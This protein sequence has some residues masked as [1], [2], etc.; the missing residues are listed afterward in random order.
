MSSSVPLPPLP[1][2]QRVGGSTFASSPCYSNLTE[3]MG[4]GLGWAFGV[5][6]G[7]LIFFPTMW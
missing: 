1:W 2:H 4:V 7:K 3:G 6:V 5:G